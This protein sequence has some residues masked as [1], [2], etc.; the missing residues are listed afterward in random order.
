MFFSSNVIFSRISYDFLGFS[1]LGQAKAA[2]RYPCPNSFTAMM[3]LWASIQGTGFAL[4]TERDWS[5]WKLGL[6][7][8][9]LT[10][11][12]AVCLIFV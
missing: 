6:D 1:R 2:Q 11:F 8:R 3:T 7:I 4:C 9:L 10:V 12:I 5:Q